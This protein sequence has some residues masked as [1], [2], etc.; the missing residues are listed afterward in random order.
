MKLTQEQI[1]INQLKAYKKVSRNW[2]LER[3][4]TRLGAITCQ[5][6]K[7]GWIFNAHFVKTEHG[8]DYIY[9]LVSEKPLNKYQLFH[10]EYQARL[11]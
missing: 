4:I 9:E 7:D 1:V 3:R 2:C 11:I 6:Q 10:K 5:L 8:K